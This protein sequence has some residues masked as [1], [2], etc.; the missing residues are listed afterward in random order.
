VQIAAKTP[1]ELRDFLDPKNPSLCTTVE[2]VEEL[3]SARNHHSRSHEDRKEFVR[4][5]HPSLH[6][7]FHD[8]YNASLD[9][10][11]LPTDRCPALKDVRE[12]LIKQRLGHIQS[13]VTSRR[14]PESR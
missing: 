7:H 3:A 9:A 12:I 5:N 14:Q 8:L 6:K 11:Y 4:R 13:Y 10:R 2:L 1:E